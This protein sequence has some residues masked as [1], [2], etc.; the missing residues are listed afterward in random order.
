MT[1]SVFLVHNFNLILIQRVINM[2]KLTLG[3]TSDPKY[4]NSK[5]HSHIKLTPNLGLEGALVL[6]DDDSSVAIGEIDKKPILVLN[7]DDLMVTN[8]HELT[9]KDNTLPLKSITISQGSS[10]FLSN[11]Y[12]GEEKAVIHVGGGCKFIQIGQDFPMKD[13][14]LEPQAEIVFTHNKS[15]YHLQNHNEIENIKI[16]DIHSLEATS[17]PL[18]TILE[19]LILCSKEEKEAIDKNLL[20]SFAGQDDLF[21][22]EEVT[23]LG[24]VLGLCSMV[25]TQNYS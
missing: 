11:N 4:K 3:S 17:K 22:I 15:A 2:P 6:E 23:S 20:V 13:I 21:K 14:I 25:I 10:V 5:F 8:S 18:T 12:V 7:L 24:E 19:K 1:S 9:I 16:N